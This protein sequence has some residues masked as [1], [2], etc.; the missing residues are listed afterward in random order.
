M[1]RGVLS[2]EGMFEPK[3]DQSSAANPVSKGN[4]LSN[5]WEFLEQVFLGILQK[6]KKNA[7]KGNVMKWGKKRETLGR[8]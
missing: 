5:R 1:F 2:G 7:R 3:T 8:N 6:K 4:H